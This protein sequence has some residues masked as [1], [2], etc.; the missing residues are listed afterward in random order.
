MGSNES[1]IIL[2]VFLESNLLESVSDDHIKL[3]SPDR[4]QPFLM[5]PFGRMVSSV[6]SNSLN[7][8]NR[9]RTKT[10]LVNTV[11]EGLLLCE[12]VST[13]LQ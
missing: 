13:T 7:Y 2:E 8:M 5:K 6:M 3:V 9:S 12:K 4:T 10:L 1:K 11:N